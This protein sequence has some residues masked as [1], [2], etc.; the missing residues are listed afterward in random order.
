LKFRIPW[1]LGSG[2]YGRDNVP[3][4]GGRKH[5]DHTQQFSSIEKLSAKKWLQA[6]RTAELGHARNRHDQF[7]LKLLNKSRGAQVWATTRIRLPKSSS[8]SAAAL[9]AISNSN[10]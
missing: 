3:P 6:A 5:P 2:F 9:L 1:G 4:Q 8:A 7:F 10:E